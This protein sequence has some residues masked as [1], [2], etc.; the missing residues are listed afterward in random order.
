MRDRQI[1]FAMGTIAAVM[2]LALALRAAANSPGQVHAST[3]PVCCVAI[4]GERSIPEEH[5][6]QAT[7]RVR[8]PLWLS[9]QRELIVAIEGSELSVEIKKI[10]LPRS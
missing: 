6:G 2:I 4:S 9:S 3:L 1:T 8:V 10:H 7:V 5:S